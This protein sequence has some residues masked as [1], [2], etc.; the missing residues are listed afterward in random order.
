VT[1][2]LDW[3]DVTSATTITETSLTYTSSSPLTYS[4]HEVAITVSDK[5]G[6]T[7][8]V[9]W[10]FT[11][12]S[13]VISIRETIPLVSQGETTSVFLQEYGSSIDEI[14][15]TATTTLKNVTFTVDISGE[16]PSNVPTPT[17][18][19][20]MYLIINTNV[21]EEDISS[22]SIHFKV[23]KAW[24][25]TTNV[26]TDKIALLKYNQGEWQ[27]LSTIKQNENETHVFYRASASGF[28]TFA[29]TGAKKISDNLTGIS[30]LI[31]FIFLVV[32]TIIA[33]A[34]LI[35]IR[36]S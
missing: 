3:R 29:I 1:L 23:E 2:T 26:D 34:I 4:H 11:I 8:T 22:A 31:I 10:R 5:A 36:R 24:F 14:T 7:A 13:E 20:Y 28:S 32:A 33:I 6:N 30:W 9:T 17:D 21:K 19:V 18:I 16:K 27:T 35:R 12:K 25:N 15:I